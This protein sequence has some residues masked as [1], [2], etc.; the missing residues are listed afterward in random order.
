MKGVPI[1][2]PEE[3]EERAR[4]IREERFR[5]LASGG[6][7]SRTKSERGQFCSIHESR[8]GSPRRMRDRRRK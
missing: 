2:S 7:A 1:P 6:H 8:G 4:L 5:E 3:I